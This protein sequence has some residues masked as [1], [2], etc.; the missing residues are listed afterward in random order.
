M[1]ETNDRSEQGAERRWHRICNT[2]GWSPESQIVHLEGFL[3]ERGLM[4]AFAE[5]AAQAANEELLCEI[6]PDPRERETCFNLSHA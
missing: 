5:Y 4:G 6:Y 3:R 1:P 2:L